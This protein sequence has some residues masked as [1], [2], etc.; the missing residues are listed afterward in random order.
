MR[1]TYL[2]NNT[3]YIGLFSICKS[4]SCSNQQCL[5]TRSNYQK[6][7]ANC[8]RGKKKKE[9]EKIQKEREQL[10]KQKKQKDK[11][12][13]KAKNHLIAFQLKRWY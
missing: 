12:L 7:A 8:R 5:Q 11:K 10:E 4:Y 3:I 2:K 1:K 6:S 9:F 13:K